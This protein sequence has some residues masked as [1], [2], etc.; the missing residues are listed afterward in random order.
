MRGLLHGND[1]NYVFGSQCLWGSSLAPLA[2]KI[3]TAAYSPS[4]SFDPNNTQFSGW[5]VCVGDDWLARSADAFP[6]A[7]AKNRKKIQR[8]RH[9][10]SCFGEKLAPSE[11]PGLYVSR[12]VAVV[13][14]LCCVP[15]TWS[16][17]I[18]C[19]QGVIDAMRWFSAADTDR[20]R[21]RL[22]GNAIISFIHSAI[23]ARQ[24][25][26]GATSLVAYGNPFDAASSAL[27]RAGK[28]TAAVCADDVS[29]YTDPP[30]CKLPRQAYGS[31]LS[32][33]LQD[34]KLIAGNARKIIMKLE[35][36]DTIRRW[37]LSKSQAQF[38]SASAE[39]FV[40]AVRQMVAHGDL[41]RRHLAFG[42]R[43]LSDS[44]QFAI[45]GEEKRE[46]VSQTCSK[47]DSKSIV[48]VRHL[49]LCSSAS[50][51]DARRR[52]ATQLLGIIHNIDAARHWSLSFTNA[53]LITI[54]RNLFSCWDKRFVDDDAR[55]FRCAFGC[56]SDQ[57][58]ETAM[59]ALG[60]PSAEHAWLDFEIR[61]LLLT[62]AFDE[63]TVMTAPRAAH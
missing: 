28:A 3:F 29:S 50:S 17:S 8:L 10:L 7:G 46:F 18:Y 60:V 20:H 22:C 30:V 56:F 12:L 54:I 1:V 52:T 5:A 55:C 4:S 62:F 37:S 51:V 14:A 36:A 53:S 48:D 32:C 44:I 21:L 2:V 39:P 23:Q 24:A 41:K 61:R 43:A 38:A 27:E 45:I 47:C 63:W 42:L 33:W 13:H 57:E 11:P 40:S 35:K 26:G 25:H 34:Y 49:F 15:V 59:S 19:V 6:P 58:L 31:F 16:I 9:R